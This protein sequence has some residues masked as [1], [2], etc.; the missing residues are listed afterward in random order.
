ML[1]DSEMHHALSDFMQSHPTLAKAPISFVNEGTFTSIKRMR[2]LMSL[3]PCGKYAKAA[4]LELRG[5]WH[6]PVMMMNDCQLL[7]PDPPV[8]I[9]RDAEDNVLARFK[10][11]SMEDVGKI[12][13]DEVFDVDNMKSRQEEQEKARRRSI[14]L[15]QGQIFLKQKRTELSMQLNST[16][17]TCVSRC[18]DEIKTL[19]KELASRLNQ[20]NVRVYHDV[21][22]YED[23]RAIRAF[24][25]GLPF[26]LQ[27]VS[28]EVERMVYLAL[29]DEVGV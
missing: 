22:S 2:T 27:T 20:H 3:D 8:M 17:E 14:Q 12:L 9:I 28:H 29:M 19:A 16:V 13:R 21:D 26:A 4:R 24:D 18:N 15:L 6:Y 5:E 10:P 1:T 11:S 23:V 25:G 7:D